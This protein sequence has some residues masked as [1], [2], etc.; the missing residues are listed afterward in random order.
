MDVPWDIGCIFVSPNLHPAVGYMKQKLALVWPM[1][2]VLKFQPRRDNHHAK[3]DRRCRYTNSGRLMTLLDLSPTDF[4]RFLTV[5]VDRRLLGGQCCLNM[6]L[7]ANGIRLT[8]R[9]MSCRHDQ[10]LPVFCRILARHSHCWFVCVFSPVGWLQ[11]S[12]SPFDVQ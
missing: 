4:R 10:M 2:H 6:G 1:R 5:P 8:K 12:G 7:V 9:C 3:R 11:Y